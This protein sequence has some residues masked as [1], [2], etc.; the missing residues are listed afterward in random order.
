MAPQYQL[1]KF[2][3]HIFEALQK[4]QFE[5]MNGSVKESLEKGVETGVF[6]K[7][8]DT[9]FTSRM[10]FNGMN[11]IKDKSIFPSQAFPM[12]TLI[13]SYLEYHLRAIV[14]EKGLKLLNKFINHNSSINA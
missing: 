2:Y 1:K 4:K 8:I 6:R 14:T 9:E 3:P 7:N 11:G 13:E 12:P 5:K 10:Y